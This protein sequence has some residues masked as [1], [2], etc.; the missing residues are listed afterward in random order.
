MQRI[1]LCA[2]VPSSGVRHRI[3]MLSN[4]KHFADLTLTTRDY[5]GA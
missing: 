3:R 5:S 1:A 2:A 4:V